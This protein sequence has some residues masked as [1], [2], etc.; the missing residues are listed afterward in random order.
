[1]FNDYLILGGAGL[2]GLQVCR[3]IARQMKP[4]IIVVASLFEREARGAVA[5]LKREFGDS[6]IHFVPS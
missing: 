4:R 1:M 5:S 3:R 6:K 2:V